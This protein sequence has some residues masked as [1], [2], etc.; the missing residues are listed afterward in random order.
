MDPLLNPRDAAI[1]AELVKTHL[2]QTDKGT[3]ITFVFHPNDDNTSLINAHVGARFVC[4]FVEVAESGEPA[5][6]PARAE[7]NAALASAHLLVREPAFRE[8]MHKNDM[9]SGASE[10]EATEG[11][12]RRLGITSRAELSKNESAKAEWLRMRAEFIAHKNYR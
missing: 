4:A 6:V 12:Y 7:N 11:L 1:E 2:R 5:D 9:A 8:W 3:Y 10:Q